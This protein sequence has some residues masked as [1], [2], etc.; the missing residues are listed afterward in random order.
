VEFDYDDLAVGKCQGLI[1]VISVGTTR[2]NGPQI[3][4]GRIWGEHLVPRR[5]A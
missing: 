4:K 3:R 5:S 1:L 2:R